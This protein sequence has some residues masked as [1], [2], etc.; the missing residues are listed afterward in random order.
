MQCDIAILQS[1][2]I[3]QASGYSTAGVLY[4]SSL[5]IT[6]TNTSL[7]SRFNSSHSSCVVLNINQQL[8]QFSLTNVNLSSYQSSGVSSL[9]AT[10]IQQS[11]NI[12]INS[13]NVCSNQQTLTESLLSY[14][15]LSQQIISACVTI[16]QG[17]ARFAYGLC[18]E[19]IKHAD[20]I[21]TNNTIACSDP[22]QFNGEIC[23]CKYGF[24]L[25]VS[26]CVDIIGMIEKIDKQS[27]SVNKDIL[28]LIEQS[29][30][31]NYSQL[32]NYMIYNISLLDSNIKNIIDTVS[33]NVS[34]NLQ[35]LEQQIISNYSKADNNLLLNTSILDKRIFDNVTDISQN[36]SSNINTLDTRIGNNVTMLSNNLRINSSNLE[37]YIVTNYS[38]LDLS[39]YSNITTLEGKMIGNVS[40]IYTNIQQNSTN[41]EQYIK[42]NFTLADNNLQSNV[43]ALTATNQQL[44]AQLDGLMYLTYTTESELLFTCDLAQYTFKQF[45]VQ[46]ITNTVNTAN[47]TN[48]FVFEQPLSNA[49]INV[50]SIDSAFTLFKNQKQFTNMKIS[51]NTIT[52]T[53]GTILT[54]ATQV[55][56][57]QMSIISVDSTQLSV[58][59]GEQFNIIQSS[60]TSCL[61]NNLLLN[62]TFSQTSL[63]GINL[64]HNQQANMSIKGYQIFGNYYSSQCVSLGAQIAQA[65]YISISAVIINPSVFTVGN[66]SSF[67]LSQ[68]SNCRIIIDSVEISIG[69]ETNFNIVTSIVSNN[70]TYMQ[71][72]GVIATINASFTQINGVTYNSFEQWYTRFT[73]N[74]GQLVGAVYYNSSQVL[75]QTICFNLNISFS[76]NTA[77]CQNFGML[78]FSNGIILLRNAIVY[79]Q[80]KNGIF[81]YFGTVGNITSTCLNATFSNLQIQMIMAYSVL[82]RLGAMN[83]ILNAQNWSIDSI[84]VKD[85]NISGQHA[86]LILGYSTNNGTVLNV[87]LL[88]S[89]I[90]VSVSNET[91]ACAGMLISWTLNSTINIQNIYSQ[92]NYI[93][94]NSQQVPVELTYKFVSMI[95]GII[96]EMYNN[97]F[98]NIIYTSQTNIS[99]ETTKHSS[100][101][102]GGI[103]G[104]IFHVCLIQDSSIK[105]ANIVSDGN[106]TARAGGFVGYI[107]TGLSADLSAQIVRINSSSSN[108]LNI[109]ATSN[110]YSYS[111]GIVGIM[112]A[113][114]LQIS[115]FSISNVNLVSQGSIY[116]ESKMVVSYP[117]GSVITIQNVV[118]QGSNVINTVLITNCL[119][120]NV[121]TQSGC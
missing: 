101:Q 70:I 116:I 71:F 58:N 39:I 81:N 67:L 22:F 80:T 47:F 66:Q 23:E 5:N 74:S 1:E 75:L 121:N 103:V 12:M 19:Q 50:L 95:G 29:I 73:N 18:L 64:V 93:Q 48:G 68:I 77:Q 38:Q 57:Q 107:Q 63:G 108:Q 56:I 76:Q 44:K 53:S 15:Q 117:I 24:I 91:N 100:S 65:S 78:G 31:S 43:S 83:G 51:L 99:L 85:S 113:T 45:N 30:I 62:L 98:V 61:I 94:A 7:Q 60:S 54:F 118:S 6:I 115:N 120:T 119:L 13:V 59:S 86:G 106:S 26:S 10:S 37:S 8:L 89:Q 11:T 69:N 90:S 97:S 36:L 114:T 40:S 34:M 112:L 46:S 2:L 27:S 4:E 92:N 102:V 111:N 14:L 96:G 82:G 16:C 84:T 32:E 87:I 41:L 55:H 21:A 25:N 33:Q 3:F 35:Y 110:N 88:S 52:F 109:R 104:N 105:Q 20:I 79:Y 9:L 17:N 72:G 42:S 28:S 49:F